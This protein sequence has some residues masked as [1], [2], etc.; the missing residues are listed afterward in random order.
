MK[1]RE[2]IRER[3]LQDVLS[4]RL[5]GLAATLGRIASSARSEKGAECVAEM[6]EEGQYFI[7]WTAAEA[8][9]DI[10]A[11]LVDM[12]IMLALWRRAWPEVQ[13]SVQQR[14]LLSL[15]APQWTN[16]ILEHVTGF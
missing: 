5:A 15:Q 16:Q 6:L 9:L 7:E 14:S 3:F 10:A 8:P 13:H 2:R 11:K 4:R 1:N 12:Q